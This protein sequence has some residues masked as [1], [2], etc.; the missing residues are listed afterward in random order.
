M[1][2]TNRLYSC[3]IYSAS[4]ETTKS[5]TFYSVFAVFVWQARNK[6]VRFW[7]D[8]NDHDILSEQDLYHLCLIY[9]LASVGYS[10]Y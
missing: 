6:G 8:K 5:I 7:H 4:G 3:D 2:C 1:V 9:N 10:F